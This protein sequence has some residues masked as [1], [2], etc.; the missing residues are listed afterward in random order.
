MS[1]MSMPTFRRWWRRAS[2]STFGQIVARQSAL[3]LWC[4]VFVIT[5]VT[6][7]MSGPTDEQT[8]F[9]LS[10]DQLCLQAAAR[11][12]VDQSR[13]VIGERV[14]VSSVEVGPMDPDVIAQYSPGSGEIRFSSSFSF[15]AEEVL[16]AAGH[17]VVHAIFDQAGLNPYV[18]HPCWDSR[19]LVEE[20]A[21]EVLGAHIAGRVRT[22]QDDDGEALTRRLVAVYRNLCDGSDPGNFRRRIWTLAPRLEPER[23]AADRLYMIAI[24]YGPVWM[25]DAI[26]EICREHPDPWVA[27]H[28]IAER[29]I[30]PIDQ[31]VITGQPSPST[32]PP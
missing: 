4:L 32:A 12:A 6:I 17:E 15:T 9:V 25:V 31:T 13:A 10:Q 26:D 2:A 27:A 22:M 8:R 5:G 11:S 20:I 24:H 14:R 16:H 29:F 19:L 23:Y 30:E 18:D 28:V 1:P 21:A 7:R 3:T